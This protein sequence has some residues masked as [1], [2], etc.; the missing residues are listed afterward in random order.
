MMSAPQGEQVQA[1][2]ILYPV[3]AS[4]E[5]ALARPD[6]RAAREREAAA[7]AGGEVSFVTEATGPAFVTREAALDAY[8]GKL[9][10]PRP[11]HGVTIAPEDRYCTI[12]ERIEGA[13][14]A[15]VEPAFARGRRWPKPPARPARTVFRLVVSY[16]RIAEAAPAS[17]P[18]LT[19]EQARAMRRRSE[20]ARLNATELRALAQQPL[21]PVKPQQPLDVGLFEVPAPEAPHI[22]IPDE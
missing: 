12:A 22:M 3:A 6:G 19:P 2:S 10:D 7:L 11:G 15:P 16:W 13:A 18:A 9:D 8:A 14:P 20:A 4:A 1:V 21:R 5:A 17:D